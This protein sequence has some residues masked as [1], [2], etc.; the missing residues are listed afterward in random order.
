MLNLDCGYHHAQD[1]F[2]HILQHIFN[3]FYILTSLYLIILPKVA[4]TA[5]P[6]QTVSILDDIESRVV[7]IR[8]LRAGTC[9]TGIIIDNKHILTTAHLVDICA[10]NQC[11][12]L[13]I[14]DKNGKEQTIRSTEKRSYRFLD[15]AT[16]K[17]AKSYG[18]NH[19]P[20]IFHAPK[21]NLDT[22]IISFPS[23][24]DL[25]NS[26][27]KLTN[28]FPFIESSA[29][30]HYG[31]SGGLII[32][33]DKNGDIFAVGIVTEGT[34]LFNNVIA[35]LLRSNFPL[36]G[37]SPLPIL[38]KSDK[39]I[40][41]LTTETF[42]KYYEQN[43]INLNSLSRLY[44][45]GRLFNRITKLNEFGIA[46]QLIPPE[47]SG[48]LSKSLIPFISALS[49]K[50]EV[51]TNYQELLI[52]SYLEE[53]G[54]EV[55]PLRYLDQQSLLSLF[56]PFKLSISEKS[57]T[58][59]LVGNKA[60]KLVFFTSCAVFLLVTAI[61]YGIT[62][63]YTYFKCLEK[64]ILRRWMLTI[65]VAV[66]LWPVSFLIFCIFFKKSGNSSSSKRLSPLQKTQDS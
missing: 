29:L 24:Q 10:E 60:L 40:L 38:T 64:S 39:Q 20:L 56:K 13:S 66:C 35:K 16:L 47:F 27:G 61:L 36:A 31:S 43:I 26:S 41:E 11:D 37:V 22:Q 2:K 44:A 48:I 17:L 7:K 55:L 18:Y 19:S 21:N 25:T 28:K 14:T 53:N 59:K 51:S 63:S 15:L 49:A 6:T 30:G 54:L 52:K 58:S 32:Q 3:F 1:L 12:D 46:K 57:L 4:A 5:E 65:L 34:S 45:G 8:S 23:C 9:G 62:I 33:S 42:L 50:S